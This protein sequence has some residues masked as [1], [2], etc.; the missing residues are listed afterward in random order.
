MI[1]RRK[2]ETRVLESNNCQNVKTK[3]IL[4]TGKILKTEFNQFTAMNACSLSPLKTVGEK[5]W[6]T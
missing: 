3:N 5:C 1:T 6:E 4:G 2:A